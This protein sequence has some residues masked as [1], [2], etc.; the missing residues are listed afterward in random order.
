MHEVVDTAH[1][2]F[3]ATERT[4]HYF[5]HQSKNP[6]LKDAAYFYNKKIDLVLMQQACELL[7][8]YSDFSCFSKSNT[9]VKTNLC[10]IT[11]A[12]WKQ[13]NDLIVF[14]ISS[15]RFLRGM[16]RTITGTMLLLGEGRISINDFENILKSKDRKQA[17]QAVDAHGLYLTHIKYPY[18][19]SVKKNTFA[20]SFN[21]L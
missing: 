14:K 9:Q 8:T 17:G 12:E 13:E 15:D 4:Y 19:V 3:D 1:A 7:K 18:L 20:L 2:R 11:F 10:N 16:V 6:F 5:I 21:L